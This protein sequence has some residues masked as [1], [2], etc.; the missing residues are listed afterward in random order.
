MADAKVKAM[1]RFAE[2]LSFLRAQKGM[3]RDVLAKSVGVKEAVLE[4][5]E[6]GDCPDS[7]TVEDLLKTAAVLEVEPDRL[8]ISK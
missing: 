6:R 4:Q 3:S 8:F 5:L 7:F 1:G 2:N